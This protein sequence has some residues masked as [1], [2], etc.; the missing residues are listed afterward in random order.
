MRKIDRRSALTL[1]VSTIAATGLSKTASARPGG[2][3]DGKVARTLDSLFY[4]VRGSRRLIE[5][6]AG[7]LVFPTIIKAGF[8]IG[9][10]YG[11]GSLLIGGTTAGYYNIVSGS[12][13]FQLGAQARSVV[14]A[15]MTGEALA[16]FER[17]DGWKVGVDGSVALITVGAGGSVDSDRIASPVVGFI[18]DGKGLMY[19]LTLEGTKISRVSR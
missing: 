11:E 12:I 19:N 9:G 10:E 16:R 7:V 2:Y 1:A 14:I 13:G 6:A 5:R 8:G 18:F 17:T 3:V 15:F 4:R